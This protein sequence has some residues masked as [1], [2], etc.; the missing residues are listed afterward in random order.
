M[1]TRL[2][3]TKCVRIEIAPSTSR[4]RFLK[5]V[6]TV[7]DPCRAAHALKSVY[8]VSKKQSRLI[9]VIIPGPVTPQYWTTG[10]A[11]LQ[12]VVVQASKSSW[13]HAKAFS[14]G[15][16]HACQRDIHCHSHDLQLFL[17]ISLLTRSLYENEAVHQTL[18]ARSFCTMSWLL[19]D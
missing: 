16:L 12:S 19:T 3:R 7:P 15:A 5:V 13:N 14:Q 2:D 11:I 8:F 4:N 1:L 10:T 18:S 17:R 6:P 9:S